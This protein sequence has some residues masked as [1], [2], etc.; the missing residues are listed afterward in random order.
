MEKG[1]TLGKMVK[2]RI[3]FH[4]LLLYEV[5]PRRK[6][7]KEDEKEGTFCNSQWISGLD[8]KKNPLDKGQGRDK[9]KGFFSS[10][11]LEDEENKKK[12]LN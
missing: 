3:H 11:S 6:K 8:K 4:M 5:A 9:R 12:G 2:A 10:F 1:S 7:E